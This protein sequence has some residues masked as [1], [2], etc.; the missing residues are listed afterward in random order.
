LYVEN[1]AGTEV[2]HDAVT[3][4]VE[5]TRDFEQ[6]KPSMNAMIFLGLIL[7]SFL[8]YLFSRLH[9]EKNELLKI[10]FSFM[11]YIIMLFSVQF[12]YN[13]LREYSKVPVII[14]TLGDLNFIFEMALIFLLAYLFIQVTLHYI[15]IIRNKGRDIYK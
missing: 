13:V 11:S 2:C 10:F 12:I 7:I 1:Y 4:S 3:F 9:D 8:L 14:D 6:G 5:R 15:N